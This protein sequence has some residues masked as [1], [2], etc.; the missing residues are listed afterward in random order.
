MNIYW[1]YHVHP[2]VYKSSF[3]CI[4]LYSES[5]YLS[6]LISHLKVLLKQMLMQICVHYTALFKM[7]KFQKWLYYYILVLFIFFT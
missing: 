5:I 7:I 4:D 2:A 1:Y 6:F 3:Y